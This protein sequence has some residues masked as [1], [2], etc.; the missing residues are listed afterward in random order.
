MKRSEE[1]RLEHIIRRMQADS[2]VDAP[3]D[4][5]LYAK[6]LYRTRSA[7]LSPSV[8]RRI[9]AVMRVDLAPDRAAFGERSGSA[10]QARQMLFESGD[11][12]IDLR[13]STAADGFDIRGQI[14]GDGFENGEVEIAG[15]QSRQTEKTD[16]M[17]GF[18]LTSIPA[19]E[20]TLTLRSTSKEIVIEHLIL[21]Q[22]S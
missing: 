1:Q 16:E 15:V 4:A 17:S 2:S 5:L 20:Y 18:G 9:I 21:K 12:A 11:N 6:N 19:G 7:E 13:L 3:T 14:L 22:P 8:I 10:G